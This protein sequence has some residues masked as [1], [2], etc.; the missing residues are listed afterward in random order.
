M[1]CDYYIRKALTILLDDIL[2]DIE[3]ELERG[4]FD[5]DFD[6]EEETYEQ[7]VEEYKVKALTPRMEPIVIYENQMFR[8]SIFETKYKTI[9]E[10]EIKRANKQWNDI[11]EI[12]KIE[13]RYKRE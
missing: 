11:V 6:K 4:Y 3:L 8:N 7:K 12:I 10:N 9:V 5:W 1:G 2:L 13:E